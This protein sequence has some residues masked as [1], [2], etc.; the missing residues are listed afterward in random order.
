MGAAGCIKSNKTIGWTLDMTDEG[1]TIS[2]FSSKVKYNL[3]EVG[4]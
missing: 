3:E 2:L 1:E 4:V